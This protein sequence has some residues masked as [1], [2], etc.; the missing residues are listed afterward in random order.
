MVG[1]NFK[2][3][4]TTSTT[5][6]V[7]LSGAN[8]LGGDYVVVMEFSGTVNP[9]AETGTSIGTT[10]AATTTHSPT[11]PAATVTPGA[12]P[13]LF[14]GAA[15]CSS[16]VYTTD[17]D[18]TAAANAA[19]QVVSYRIQADTTAQGF[20]ITSDANEGCG[21]ALMAIEGDAGGGGATASPR[22]LLL[23]VGN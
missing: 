20:T 3:V 21:I 23:G 4:S 12:A 18:F 5:V 10:T 22:R 11:T 8:A 15:M 13:V 9:A 14:V 2:R 6:T 16:G 7:T 17:A 19:R 1:F